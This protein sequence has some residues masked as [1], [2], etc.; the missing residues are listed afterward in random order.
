MMQVASFWC[1]KFLCG[2]QVLQN[3]SLHPVDQ[4]LCLFAQSANNYPAFVCLLFSWAH[5]YLLG[6]LASGGRAWKWKHVYNN[7]PK[8]LINKCY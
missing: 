1:E 2:F 3:T 8:I 7:Q 5:K 4:K 6:P